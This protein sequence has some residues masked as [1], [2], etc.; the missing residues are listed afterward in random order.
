MTI[1]DRK[2]LEKVTRPTREHPCSLYRLAISV[3]N[4]SQKIWLVYSIYNGISEPEESWYKFHEPLRFN[5]RHLIHLFQHSWNVNGLLE[6]K[7]F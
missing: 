3:P 2:M 4:P 5:R 6:H 7:P 1:S